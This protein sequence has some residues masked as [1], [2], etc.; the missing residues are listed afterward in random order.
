MRNTQTRAARATAHA[1]GKS[2]AVRLAVGSFH[3]RAHQ[4]ALTTERLPGLLVSFAYLQ[5]FLKNRH[6]YRFRDWMAT[7]HK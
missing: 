4:R 1:E 6:R 2:P 7:P 3:E 5:P